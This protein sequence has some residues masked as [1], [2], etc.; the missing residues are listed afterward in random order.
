VISA[1]ENLYF[2][3]TL[4]NYRET[5]KWSF[6]WSSKG[7]DGVQADAASLGVSTLAFGLARVPVRILPLED[8]LGFSA[9][10]VP[11]R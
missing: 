8:S 9:R 7:V 2:S 1:I 6:P 11:V 3:I 4:T 10:E 5:V